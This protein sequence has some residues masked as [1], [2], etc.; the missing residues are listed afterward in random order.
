V[1]D[2]EAVTRS[3]L[4]SLGWALADVDRLIAGPKRS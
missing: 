1:L 4:F 2:D 3:Y